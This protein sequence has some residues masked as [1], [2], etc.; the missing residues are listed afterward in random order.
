[1][2]AVHS[3]K[4]F[5]M[6]IRTTCPIKITILH[7][8]ECANG[9]FHLNKKIVTYPCFIDC[10]SPYQGNRVRFITLLYKKSLKIYIKRF[11]WEN[12]T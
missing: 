12:K 11:V 8:H 2:C 4:H 1:M 6:N 5:Y 9:H 3:S 7:I 10:F